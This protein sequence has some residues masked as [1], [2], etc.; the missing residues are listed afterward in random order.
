MGLLGSHT[1]IAA[2]NLRNGWM[3]LEVV[4]NKRIDRMVRIIANFLL[5]PPFTT[6]PNHKQQ[7]PPTTAESTKSFLS[8]TSL[9]SQFPFLG[10]FAQL[11]K[12]GEN[13]QLPKLSPFPKG[14]SYLLMPLPNDWLRYN[15]GLLIF[16]RN[17]LQKKVV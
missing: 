5:P 8:V 15:Y 10:S 17:F 2:T 3:I 16:C 4:K 9:R 6:K 14:E 7:P 13:C 1:G 11:R 12:A